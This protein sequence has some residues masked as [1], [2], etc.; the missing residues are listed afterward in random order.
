MIFELTFFIYKVKYDF[1]LLTFNVFF[2]NA[3]ISLLSSFINVML[4]VLS[5]KWPE[6]PQPHFRG[7]CQIDNFCLCNKKC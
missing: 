1:F 3:C 5:G 6:A 2:F 4:K 7:H